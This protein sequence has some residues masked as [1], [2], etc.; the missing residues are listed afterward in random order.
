MLSGLNHLTLSVKNLELSLHFYHTILGMQLKASWATGA[1]LSC[2]PL[3]LCLSMNKYLEPIVSGYT[4]YA[5]SIDQ[6]NFSKFCMHLLDHKVAMWQENS[7]EGD[8]F[9]FLDPDG[10]QLELHVGDLDS[11]LQSCKAH[12]YTNMKFYE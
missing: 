8:S 9:Y 5:F 7:S 10:H 1:Y 4:H 3:W 12:P 11:R 2:G 6:K